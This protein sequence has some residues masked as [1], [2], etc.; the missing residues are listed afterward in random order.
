MRAEF[1]NPS[2]FLRPGN[3]AKVKML[4]TEKQDALLVSERALGADQ[5]GPFVLVVNSQ[6]VVEQRTVVTGPQLKGMVAIEPFDAGKL[7]G[8]K[9]D[10]LVVVK[11]LQ[12]ARPGSTV[13]PEREELKTLAGEPL[14]KVNAQ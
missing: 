3:Y 8:I 7:T 9:P 4:L 13:A 5:S 11:G 2:H 6:N 10:D 1:P 12:R 14:V